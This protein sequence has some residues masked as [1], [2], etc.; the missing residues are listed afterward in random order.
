MNFT[1]FSYQ[2]SATIVSI[3]ILTLSTGCSQDDSEH[4]EEVHLERN[5][6]YVE[7]VLL[8]RQTMFE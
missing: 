2:D 3:A 4:D 8:E 5:E 7:T 6:T 1:R